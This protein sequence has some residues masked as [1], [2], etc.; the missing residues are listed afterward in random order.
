MRTFQLD[1]EIARL[2]VEG[3]REGAQAQAPHGASE[4][5]GPSAGGVLA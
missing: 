3:E 2:P 1:S 4:I 5:A